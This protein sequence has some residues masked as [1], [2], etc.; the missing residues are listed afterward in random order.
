MTSSTQ[1]SLATLLKQRLQIISDHAFRDRDPE[2]H[3]AALG[4]V[5]QELADLYKSAKPEMPPRLRHF[6]EQCSYSKA[7]DFI[8]IGSPGEGHQ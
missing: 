3:L 6:M 4:K 2:A 5:S 1:E 8:E 7:L